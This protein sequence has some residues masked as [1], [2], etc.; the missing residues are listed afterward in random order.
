MTVVNKTQTAA[1]TTPKAKIFMPTH[2]QL[3]STYRSIVESAEKHGT[4]KK[5]TRA[6]AGADKAQGLNITPPRTLGRSQTAYVI[7]GEIYVKSTILSPTA[8]P[9]WTKVGP[10]P[11]F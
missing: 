4:A 5:L 10:A 1:A 6:P 11:L 7:K 2:D 9:T 3:V 8:K